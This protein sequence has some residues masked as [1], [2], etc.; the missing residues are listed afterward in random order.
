VTAEDA[1]RTKPTA[2]TRAEEARDARVHSGASID[3][4]VPPVDDE[5]EPEVSGEVADHYREM[6]ER[7]ANQKGEGRLP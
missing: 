7:G 4:A 5:Q 3:D 2:A 6:V 1:K